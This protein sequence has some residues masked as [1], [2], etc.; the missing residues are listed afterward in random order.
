MK[1]ATITLNPA[2]DLTVVASHFAL[3]AVNRGE[4]MR[5]DPGGKGINVASY[6]ADYGCEVAATGFMGRENAEI[7]ERLFAEKHIVDRFVRVHGQNRVG[8]KIV[9]PA[10]QTT[11]DL[12]MPGLAPRDEDVARLLETVARMAATGEFGWFALSGRLPLGLPD[13]FYAVLIERLTKA[14]VR[15]ALDTSQAALRSGAAAGPTLLKPNMDELQQLVGREL[16][17][18][19][20]IEQAARG[21]LD[22]GIQWVVVS[23]GRR[24]ALLVDRAGAWLAQPPDVQVASTVGAGDAMVAG[25]MAGFE[26]GLNLADCGRL[27]TAF[28][29]SAVTRVGAHLP[30][31]AELEFYARQVASRRLR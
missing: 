1:F 9:D 8:I 27:A 29:A 11:T 6:L 28:A 2:I 15:T 26:Q 19:E 3:D 13:D 24:G 22:G 16:G 30:A 25:L 21:L 23:M 12:N 17:S 7:F 14:G 20:D 31:R 18:E 4:S 10:Q 5:F